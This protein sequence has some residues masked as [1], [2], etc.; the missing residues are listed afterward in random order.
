[1]SDHSRV[2]Q[3]LMPEGAELTKS[4][5]RALARQQLKSGARDW[6][7]LEIKLGSKIVVYA[8]M[9][10]AGRPPDPVFTV[11]ESADAD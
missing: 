9:D 11:P 10:R 7:M 6:D 3:I 8:R 4:R 1:M 5:V 2:Y